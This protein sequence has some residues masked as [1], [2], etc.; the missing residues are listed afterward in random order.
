MQVDIVIIPS[1]S[2]VS[3]NGIAI[4]L[5][6]SPE[7]N[8]VRL[9]AVLART[10]RFLAVHFVEHGFHAFLEGFVFR[11]LVELA[12]EMAADFERVVG[13]VEG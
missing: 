9:F 2:P 12:D 13:E 3:K 1:P 5:G 11:A 4:H 10:F 6:E 7:S 8:K